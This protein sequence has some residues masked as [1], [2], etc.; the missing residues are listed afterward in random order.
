MIDRLKKLVSHQGFMKYFKNTSWLFA[1]KILRMGVGLFVGI[2]VARYLGPEQFGLLSYAQSFVGLFAIVAGLGLDGVIVRELVN[3][4]KKE[5][6]LLSTAFVLK[7][8]GAFFTLLILLFAISLTSNDAYTKKLVFIIASAVIFKS[9]NVIDFYFQAKVMSKYVVFANSTAFLLSS[10]VKIYLLL[11]HAPL[12]AFAWVVL[13]DAVIMAIGY[14]YWYVKINKK[15]SFFRHLYFDRSIARALLRDSWP[16]VLSGIALTIYLKID[17][18]MI[19]NMLDNNAIGNYAAAVRL[20]EAWY[21]IPVIIINTLFPAILKAKQVNHELYFQRLQYLYN[22][23]V[24]ISFI[25][26]IFVSVFHEKIIVLLFGT[27]YSEASGVLAIHVWAGI[28]FSLSAASGKFLLA[29]NYRFYQLFRYGIGAIVNIVLNIILIPTLQIKGAA[30]ATL[31]SIV[32]TGFILD[33]FVA[34]MREIAFMKLKALMLM[35]VFD[36]KKYIIR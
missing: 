29:E 4:P 1:E 18:I 5:K 32:I 27:Q 28:F 30:I 22:L 13:F 10:I 34:Q 12:E 6:R 26:A 14:I 9:F 17:Q 15:N 31:I 11:H 19:K 2:W 8:F 16:L 24:F 3:R 25:A 20:S 33:F 21:F 7:L 23:V 36:I 35:F